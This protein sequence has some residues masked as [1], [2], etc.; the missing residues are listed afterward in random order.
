M[1][2]FLPFEEKAVKLQNRLKKV[3]N[4][5]KKAEL[6]KELL[7]VRKKIEENLS[8]WE[9][10][11]LARH[12]SRPRSSDL[13]PLIFKDIIPVHG[14]F[15][16]KDDR[17]IIAGFGTVGDVKA[18]FIAQEKSRKKENILSAA[19]IRKAIRMLEKAEQ[20]NL[21]VVTLVDNPGTFPGFKREEEGLAYWIARILKEMYRVSVPTISV[22]IGEGGSGGAIAFSLADRILMLK[23]TIFMVIAPEA[24]SVIIYRD[25]EH[26]EEVAKNMKILAEELLELGLIDDIVPEPIGGA[27]WDYEETAKLISD[28]LVEHFRSLF[29]IDK[30]DR[31][32]MRKNKFLSVGVKE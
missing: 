3:K 6:E 2:K 4:G 17:S 15:C 28:K 18:A 19:G 30:A 14:D 1:K 16:S 26:T 7:A 9:K 12:P 32:E 29:S 22:V 13:I 24:S 5:N 27:H 31:L 10:V 11:Q 25:L 8:Y 21:P 20:F 23:H